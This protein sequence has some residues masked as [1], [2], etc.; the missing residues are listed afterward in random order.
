MRKNAGAIDKI[1]F[2][3]FP[4]SPSGTDIPRSSQPHDKM[5]FGSVGIG[6]G[7]AHGFDCC[8]VR[9][10]SECNVATVPCA[11]TETERPL[12]VSYCK[13]VSRP[14]GCARYAATSASSRLPSANAGTASGQ[15]PIVSMKRT[16]GRT[17]RSARLIFR[18]AGA[19]A[20]FA[21]VTVSGGAHEEK[22]H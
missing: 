7:S 9:Q 20:S 11:E 15:S 1:G 10:C 19:C 21:I 18:P 6:Q 5:K 8:L 12:W 4:E 16:R 13:L 2:D 14:C 17:I 3:G 22:D